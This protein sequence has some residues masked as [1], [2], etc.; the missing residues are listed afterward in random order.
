MLRRHSFIS[1]LAIGTA[2]F[3]L[4]GH[5]AA[6]TTPPGT[7]SGD[8]V[9]ITFW[10]SYGNGGNSVQQDA[11]NKTLIPAFEAAHPGIKVEYV[12]VPYDAL[13]QKIA[14]S[15]S[16][17]ALPDLI[18]ADLGWVPQFASQGLVLP[19]SDAMAD[20]STLAAAT[21]PGSLATNHFQG[22]YYGLPLDTNT[23][24]LI[25]SQQAL[26]AAEERLW[27]KRVEQGLTRNSG[28]VTEVFEQIGSVNEIGE[29]PNATERL[30]LERA[31]AKITAAIAVVDEFFS[32][33]LTTFRAA[34][35]E[36]GLG[37][38]PQMP[39]TK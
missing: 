5:A 33:P 4:A 29:A 6:S 2:L 35:E 25:T 3:G 1:V 12:D 13:L 17:D 10:G 9:T 22:K 30:G 21:Y 32:G 20:F 37:L 27:G 15:A 16:G 31:V 39:T 11:L 14:T 23:R 19:L 28:L 36:S 8:P 38:A 26:D 7:A 18:R 24:V 34:V